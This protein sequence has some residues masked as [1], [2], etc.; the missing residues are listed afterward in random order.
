MSGAARQGDPAP[1]PAWMFAV[2]FLCLVLPARSAIAAYGAG[3]AGM[4][5]VL[6]LFVL[7]LLY[8]VPPGRA[9]WAR[10]RVPL[11][12]VQAVLTYVPFLVFGQDWVVGL[13]GL[14]GGLLL[15]TVKAPASWVLFG[16][17]LLLEGALRVG[18]S[19]PL[20]AWALTAP[21][22][23]ALALFGLARLADL[24]A[25]LHSTQAELV[26]VTVARQ[27]LRAAGLLREAI[28]DRLEAVTAHAKAALPMLTDN[29]GRA[30][31]RLTEAAGIARQALDQVRVAVAAHAH[32]PSEAGRAGGSE[33][34]TAGG[35]TG[36]T[37]APRVA[38]LVLAVV[39][40]A[41]STQVLVNIVGSGAAAPVEI[42]AACVIVAIVALQLRH[43]PA[44]RDGGRP[45]AGPGLSPLRRC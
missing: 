9:V 15:L 5:V 33:G 21:V 31:D 34:D 10:H 43:T 42:G 37:V 39:L 20:T 7:P 3:P 18:D 29:P 44:R 36:D 27:R 24:V 41:F 32:G 11:L 25:D 40:C 4:A 30:R 12:V 17:V 14:L 19:L 8:A 22:N 2:A 1:G 35:G 23:L 6:A 38:R 26:A 13:S 16:A 28:G 45:G